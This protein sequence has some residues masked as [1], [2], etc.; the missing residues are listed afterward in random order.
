MAIARLLA[1]VV[2]LASLLVPPFAEASPSAGPT[3][4]VSAPM[5]QDGTAD[6]PSRPHGI[7]HA[8]PHCACQLADRLVPPQT[9]ERPRL[10]ITLDRPVPLADRAR[11]S[12]EAEP[13]ARPPRA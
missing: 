12:H 8:G 3:A 5:N 7:L 13:P 11:A 6:A 10:A 4:L 9:V 2:L 1:L